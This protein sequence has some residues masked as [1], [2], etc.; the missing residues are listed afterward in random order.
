MNLTTG[1]IL[2]SN[3]VECPNWDGKLFSNKPAQIYNNL[4]QLLHALESWLKYKNFDS[5]TNQLKIIPLNNKQIGD[6]LIAGEI[7]L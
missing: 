3:D 5:I 7:S 4:F 6:K 2:V 1:Y